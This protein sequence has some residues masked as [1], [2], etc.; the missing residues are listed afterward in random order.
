ML[1]KQYSAVLRKM[2]IILHPRLKFQ[3]GGGAM[4]RFVPLY[5]NGKVLEFALKPCW[6]LD[7]RLLNLDIVGRFYGSSSPFKYILSRSFVPAEA[8]NT[9]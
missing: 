3:S 8:R 2:S 9:R 5:T 6:L 1:N 4:Q 7:K